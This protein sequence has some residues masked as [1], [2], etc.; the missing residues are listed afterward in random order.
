[1]CMLNNNHE[2]HYARLLMQE[3]GLEGMLEVRG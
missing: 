2:S 3:P 1:V